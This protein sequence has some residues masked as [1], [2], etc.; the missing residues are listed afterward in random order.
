MK[1]IISISKKQSYGRSELKLKFKVR[2]NDKFVWLCANSNIFVHPEDW[3]E[4]AQSIMRYETKRI[5]TEEIKDARQQADN[6]AKLLSHINAAWEAADKNIITKDWLADVVDKYNFPEKYAPKEEQEE[7]KDI[8]DLFKDYLADKKF[9]ID[10]EKGNMVMLRSVVRYEMFVRATDN[11]EFVF[12]IN[13]IDKDTIE[14]YRDYIAN[15]KQLSEEHPQLFKRIFASYPANVKKGNNTIEDRG[16][17]AVFKL[18]KKLKA[19][20]S[21]LNKKGIT[22]NMPFVGV[23]LGKEQFGE[24][25]YITLEERN[26]I[27]SAPMPTKHL[28]TQRDIFIFHCFVGCRVSDLIKLSAANVTD[29]ILTYTPHKTKDEGQ[30]ALQARVPLHSVAQ[31]LIKKYEGKDTKGR[32]FPFITP[33]KYND[34][35]KDIFTVTGIIRNVEVRNALTGETEIRPINEVAS[36]H[37]ARRTFC[38]NL[39]SKVQDPNL[40]GKMSGH[41]EGS[42]AFTRYRKIEDKTLKDTINLIG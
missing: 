41:V 14:D 10:F 38:G 35:I 30:Q 32:L 33:Q 31:E 40:I 13:T 5:I 23:E 39:Y 20:F 1:I 24:P 26:L 16:S 12:D 29:G 15:E 4:D 19:F 17:N 3:N 27:A 9:S 6:L 28:E 7:V 34:A 25:Y 36:S 18:M 8:Y 11:K 22:S 42:K 2:Q 21:W 37:L